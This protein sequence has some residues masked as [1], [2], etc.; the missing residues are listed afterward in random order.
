MRGSRQLKKCM[1]VL[2]AVAVGVTGI[3]ALPQ[4]RMEADAMTDKTMDE[5]DEI[6][7]TYSVDSSVPDY[8]SYVKNYNAVYPDARIEVEAGAYVR[9]EEE[10]AAAEPQVFSDYQGTSGH[11]SLIHI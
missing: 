10:N 2:L 6:V 4:A 5:Y 9:Y 3:T 8:K 11:L 1:A 7:S